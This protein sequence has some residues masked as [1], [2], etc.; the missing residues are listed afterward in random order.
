MIE[1]KQTEEELRYVAESLALSQEVAGV[2]SWDWNFQN[3]V[4]T[5]SDE[6]Y[7]H[8]GL[9]PKE[10]IP[11]YEA[12]ES[13]IHPDDKEFVNKEVQRAI[14]R[15]NLYS[16]DARMVRTDGTTWIMHTEGRVYKDN[17]GEVVGFIG[18]QQDI[19]ERKQAEEALRESEDQYRIL[20]DQSPVGVG[21]ATL[22]GRIINANMGMSEITGY[23]LE[24]LKDLNLA[25]TYVKSEDR[26]KLLETL[27]RYGRVTDFVTQLKRKDGAIYQAILNIGVIQS[28]GEKLVQTVCIDIT[29][30]KQAEEEL[31]ASKAFL[32][33]T[34]QIAKIGGWEMDV[35]TQDGKWTDEIF[36]LF[37]L[38]V[39]DGPPPLNDQLKFFHLDNV[40]KLTQVMQLASE[41]GEPYD[42]ELR[43]I[44]AKGNQIW[45]QAICTP[46]IEDGKTV[47]LTGTFQDITERKETE[48]ALVESEGR[49]RTLFE[50]MVQ[51]VVYQDTKGSITNA[52]PAAERCLGLT[53]DQM[54]GRTSIDPRWKSIHEDGSDFPGETHPA[55]VSLRTGNPV[56]NVVMGV[57]N[58]NDEEYHWI[59]INAIPMYKPSEKIP[60]QVYT[61]FDDITERKQAEEELRASE[62][63]YRTLV[64]N[65][66]D[67]I[68]MV[69]KDK[70]IL[71]VN[72]AG[73]RLLHK[74]SDEII[75]KTV[76]DLFPEVF[77]GRF[78]GNLNR[79][80]ETAVPHTDEDDLIMDEEKIW[81]STSLSPIRNLANEVVAVIGVTRDIT[82]RKRMEE[83][84]RVYV[85]GIESSNDG[86]AFVMMNGDIRY[87][88]KAAC[89]IF[90]YTPAEMKELNISEF[91]ATPVDEEMLEGSVR[92]KGGFVGEIMGVRKDG[93]T[94]PATLSVSIVSD[95]IGNPIGRMG[96]FRDVTELKQI[97]EER[98]KFTKLE[99]VGILAGG[100]AHD[101]NNILTGI[102]G[103]ISLA[104]RYVEPKSKA[105][106]RLLEAE[107]ASIRARDLTQ[108]LLTFSRGG[109]PIKKI[110][111]ITGLLKDSI[112][113]ALRGS[114]IK[115]DFEL[116]DNLSPVEVDE[117]QVNQVIANLIINAQEAMPEGGVI[118]L[119]ARNTDIADKRTLPLS[120]GRYVVITIVDHGVGI[121]KEHLDR[122]FD[123]YFTTKQKGSGLGLATSY[124]IIKNHDGYITA[125]STLGVGTTFEIFLPVSKKLVVEV[126]ET[127]AKGV[128]AG[129]GRILVMDDE[130]IVQ[131]FLLSGLTGIGYEVVLTKDG[132]EAIESYV[133]AKESG[134][135][136]AAVIMDLTIPGGM[137]GKE[138]IKKLLEVDPDARVIVSSGYATDPIMANFEEYGFSGVITKPYI[139]EKLG[140]TLFKLLTKKK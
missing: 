11:T 72:D 30:R 135:P 89:N 86:I 116:P 103:N 4:L 15:E 7:R 62:E 18:A 57:F 44:T 109:A 29:E 96:V 58:P 14:S 24:E 26:K 98:Q 102:M 123:P 126:E 68:Y 5:W 64:E 37:E 134:Q 66:T 87:F 33:V 106:E 115:C 95:D 61:T 113:F 55:M 111:S 50:T 132:V 13:F 1:R 59:N 9:K 121:K 117:G 81:I 25:D 35:A 53:L 6:T 101:F 120:K 80:F 43:V 17:S 118:N 60:Y 28:K 108:Q 91:S 10:I 122:I 22:D 32:E 73:A 139:I 124:S 112:D 34:G 85:A 138:A 104:K 54:Q 76:L 92:E 97:E 21:I 127:N 79:V 69:G 31:R 119:N 16:I 47:K 77:G 137:G 27:N 41:H 63:K 2:G 99:S 23:S 110:V 74:N 94:F 125:D 20:F 75:G 40:P 42:I 51:G 56:R 49:Y 88:N 140:E 82:E 70:R 100:I 128:I 114:N 45:T 133:K 71:S 83:E 46:I 38:P 90:G 136:F 131:Q 48:K 52:N 3:N 107:K 8:F 36:C 12:F 93:E 67:I 129:G 39:E 78:S 65:T 19:T 105:E 84:M 130:E